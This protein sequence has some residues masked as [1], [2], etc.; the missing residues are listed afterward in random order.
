[1]L[2][3]FV[4]VMGADSDARSR[5]AT[6]V[7]RAEQPIVRSMVEEG[8]ANTWVALKV[9]RG[10]Q[11]CALHMVAA[12]DVGFQAD[13]L[14]LQEANQGFV[15]DMEGGRGARLKTALV[16]LKDRPGCA[17]LMG[18]GAVVNTKGVQRVLR[19]VLGTAKLMV[20]ESDAYLQDAPKE[21]KGARRCARDTVGESA[22]C[23]MVVEFAQKVFMEAQTFV[24]PMVVERGVL[25]QAVQRVRVAV[26]IAVLSMVEGSG[27]GLTTVGRVPKVALTSAKLMVGVND[28]PGVR[29][30]AR[31]L[32]GV[33][34]VYVLHT[35]AWSKRGRQTGLV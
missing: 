19:G 2:Q 16:V 9:L 4:L 25:C 32:P 7:L 21:L 20:G 12:G 29:E 18:V 35:A 31:S 28:A 23:L 17:F 10:R 22:A 1:M 3:A 30:N 14:R 15:L 34:V 27:A 8:G 13:A 11:I 26:L 6:K 33:R 5:V 24:L